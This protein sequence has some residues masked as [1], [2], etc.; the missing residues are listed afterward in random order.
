MLTNCLQNNQLNEESNYFQI[1]INLNNTL[2][3]Y[4]FCFFITFYAF[5]MYFKIFILMFHIII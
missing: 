4:G 3:I 2:L 1:N 5:F